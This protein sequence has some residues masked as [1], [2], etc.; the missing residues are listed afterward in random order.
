MKFVADN[1][2]VFI[3][4]A[5]REHRVGRSFSL[6]QFL[7]QRM[8]GGIPFFSDRSVSHAFLLEVCI[9]ARQGGRCCVVG[10]HVLGVGPLQYGIRLL[11]VE[12]LVSERGD[13]IAEGAQI[14]PCVSLPYG[15]VMK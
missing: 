8:D 3:F 11:Q 13:G 4:T 5:S 2:P 14:C 9:S 7:L 15:D 1:A 12:F 10:C 6:V